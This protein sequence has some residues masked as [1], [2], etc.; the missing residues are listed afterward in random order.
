MLEEITNST[1]FTLIAF[2]L[3]F[4]SVVLA[5]LF[6]YRSQIIKLPHYARTGE[7][8]IEENIIQHKPI[9]VL[10]QDKPVERLTKTY[11]ALWNKGRATIRSED[12]TQEDP[13][14]LVPEVGTTILATEILFQ[15]RPAN[16]IQ[17]VPDPISSRVTIEFDFLDYNN[18][19]II[20]VYHTGSSFRGVDLVGT[21]KGATSLIDIDRLPST[22]IDWLEK[23]RE[24]LLPRAFSFVP[25]WFIKLNDLAE[26][27]QNI[28]LAFFSSFPI[29]IVMLPFFLAYMVMTLIIF[30]PLLIY[31]PFSIWKHSLPNELYSIWKGI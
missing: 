18:G 9:K 25:Q 3:T 5:I 21:V 13:L 14:R 26:D 10:F 29:M 12:L 7:T 4:M 1:L 22:M 27:R 2:I 24:R 20:V 11:L 31:M 16:K 30:I 17:L 15:N 23:I 28:L 6:Y 8:L 19:V